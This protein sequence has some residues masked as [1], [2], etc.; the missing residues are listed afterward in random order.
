MLDR[1]IDRLNQEVD[2]I[3]V[4]SYREHEGAL[5]LVEDMNSHAEVLGKQE[6]EYR[7]HIEKLKD[8]HKLPNQTL[9]E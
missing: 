8:I 6:Y 7:E 4:E 1:W 3:L 9:L 5:E 2:E